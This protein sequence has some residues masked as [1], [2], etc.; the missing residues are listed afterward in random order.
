MPGIPK[1]K[2]AIGYYV[3]PI[4]NDPTPRDIGDPAKARVET[5]KWLKGEGAV[6]EQFNILLPDD[7][8]ALDHYRKDLWLHPERT[9]T[10]GRGVHQFIAEA[11]DAEKV[12]LKSEQNRR[13]RATRE[14]TQ[15]AAKD[16]VKV[17]LI[18]KAKWEKYALKCPRREDD[19]LKEMATRIQ[20]HLLERGWAPFKISENELQALCDECDTARQDV[21]LWKD[22]PTVER[23]EMGYF[24]SHD[25]IVRFLGNP[26]KRKRQRKTL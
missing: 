18:G 7:E 17:R 13:Q 23:N 11:G 10:L 4:N 20:R 1:Q 2:T 26:D 8:E 15:K 12:R 25:T 14:Q 19:T 6:P 16:G 9:A 3:G 24:P 5:L 22:I 21:R